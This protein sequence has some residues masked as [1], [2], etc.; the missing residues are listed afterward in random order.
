MGWAENESNKRWEAEQKA[1]QVEDTGE[2]KLRIAEYM[3]IVPMRDLWC[4]FARENEKLPT[5][6]RLKKIYPNAI[7][8]IRLIDGGIWCIQLSWLNANRSTSTLLISYDRE[9]QQ[10]KIGGFDTKSSDRR[11]TILF[12]PELDIESVLKA[13]ILKLDASQLYTDLC[14][15]R[16]DR[17]T[18][19][20]PKIKQGKPSFWERVFGY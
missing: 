3:S 7:E 1:K 4:W 16:S 5:N 20:L 13:I 11:A 8:S 15:K 6:I 2:E 10:Y 9:I 12:L 14:V 17:R 18:D 19:T